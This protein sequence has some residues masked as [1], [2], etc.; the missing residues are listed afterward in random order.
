M[1]ATLI[2]LINNGLSLALDFRG[3]SAMRMDEN[4]RSLVVGQGWRE[5]VRI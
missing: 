2:T 5:K 3:A 1:A 4:G